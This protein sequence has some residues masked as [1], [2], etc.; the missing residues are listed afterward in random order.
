LNNKEE[1]DLKTEKREFVMS[2]TSYHD[3]TPRHLA[4]N[5]IVEVGEVKLLLYGE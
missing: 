3:S 2:P 5:I 4:A 1:K